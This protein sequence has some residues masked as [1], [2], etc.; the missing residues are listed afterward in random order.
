M[1][2]LR[3]AVELGARWIEFDVK[4]TA[5]NELVLFHDDTLK[6]T[7]DGKGRVAH[8]TLAEIRMLDAGRWFSPDFT[9]EPV[10][11]LAEAMDYLAAN[12]IGANVEVKAC[13]GREAETGAATARALAARWFGGPIPIL[14]SSFSADSLAAARQAAP[15]IPRGFLTLR[16]SK[17]WAA[18][19]RELECATFHVL[20]RRLTE[21]R[22]R[23]IREADYR[24]LA[25]TVNDPRRARDLL[26]WGVESIITDY[27]ERIMAA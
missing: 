1:A 23:A 5:D 3:K 16:F 21:A 15:Q 26:S 10:P 17:D 9:G 2:G 14:I 8:T 7:T 20:D 25:Y 27:P 22:V 11:T 13:P 19:M 4:L 24:A 6:R 18:R 12:G